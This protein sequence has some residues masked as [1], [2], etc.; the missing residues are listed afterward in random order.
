MKDA[1]AFFK[2]MGLDPRL[3]RAISHKTL[4]PI[5]KRTI[6]AILANQNILG[7]AR[8]GSGKT[9]AYLI[10]VV[11]K[12]ISGKRALILVPTRDL[13]HQVHKV[14]RKLTRNLEVKVALAHGGIKAAESD[15]DIIIATV[16]RLLHD[17]QDVKIDILVVDEIDRMLEEDGMRSDFQM[18][19]EKLP[20]GKQTIYFSATLPNRMI[21]IVSELRLIK[22]DTDLS[23]TLQH[24][25]FYVPS[26][27]KESALLFLM[28]RI[29]AKT[30]VFT[31]TKYAV[32]LAGNVLKEYNVRTIYSSMD[33]ALRKK[34][35]DDFIKGVTSVLIVTDLAARGLDIPDLDIAINYDLCDEKTFLHRVGRV[36]RNGRAGTQYSIVSYRDVFFFFAI[37]ERYFPE[38]EIGVI[39]S[40]ILNAFDE[41]LKNADLDAMRKIAEKAS[42]KAHKF[43]KK[44]NLETDY[45]KQI[46]DIKVHSYFKESVVADSGKLCTSVPCETRA[47]NASQPISTMAED[48]F[49]D[50][51][52]IPYTTRKKHK[53]ST[54]KT[55]AKRFENKS[56][57]AIGEEWRRRK[58]ILFGKGDGKK[59]C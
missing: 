45:R 46:Q 18:L 14:L 41:N 28:S 43:S 24:Y 25:F 34:N 39:P 59:T 54:F 47:E 12:V 35:M 22:V 10:P 15:Y 2:K 17:G 4:T 36:A 53:H 44:T 16:G 50:E 58:N 37:R 31:S 57:N 29:S 20:K 5:Q 40:E 42:S 48:V 19:E 21:E 49:R 27:L 30:I 56:I 3:T 7:I 38:M 1:S 26:P 6:P 11:Q 8:T 51:L 9:L 32:E 23:S 55:S 13:V 33:N 52:F